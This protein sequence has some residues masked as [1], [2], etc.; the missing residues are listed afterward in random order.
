MM[1]INGDILMIEKRCR[2]CMHSTKFHNN[3]YIEDENYMHR[4]CYE[5]L[6]D[7]NNDKKQRAFI[8]LVKTI[9]SKMV[10]VQGK[11]LPSNKWRE[12]SS[13]LQFFETITRIN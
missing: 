4:Q 13:P 2:V 12:G 3:A 7:P 9:E 8:Q 1:L 5:V 6:N 11:A 10:Y